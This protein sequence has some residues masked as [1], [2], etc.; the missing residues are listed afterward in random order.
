MSA[1]TCEEC[2]EPYAR[3]HCPPDIIDCW[4]HPYCPAV[5]RGFELRV[6]PGF[7]ST[8]GSGN[9]F[10]GSR[11][12]GRSEIEPGVGPVN[13]PLDNAPV[14]PREEPHV[15]DRP[16]GGGVKLE[17]RRAMEPAVLEMLPVERAELDDAAAIERAIEEAVAV[18]HDALAIPENLSPEIHPESSRLHG[19]TGARGESN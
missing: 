9:T 14:D 1:P 17:L 7:E 11:G 16:G 6:A 4:A 3:W 13:P 12:D 10:F 19:S 5:G 8:S 18:H 2:G 15:V